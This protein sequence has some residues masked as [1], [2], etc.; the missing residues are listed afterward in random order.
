MHIPQ[1][2]AANQTTGLGFQLSGWVCGHHK[3]QLA[4]ILTTQEISPAKHRAGIFAWSQVTYH[5]YI[6]LLVRELL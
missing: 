3:T 2:K 4:W 1:V 5:N 6:R